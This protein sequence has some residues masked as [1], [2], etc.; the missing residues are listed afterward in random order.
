MTDMRFRA[1]GIENNP[2]LGILKSRLNSL[3]ACRNPEFLCAGNP[4]RLR[5]NTRK[6][7][8]LHMSGIPQELVHQVGTDV[9]GTKNRDFDRL[10]FAH[11]HSS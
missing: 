2:D 7:C 5:V 1:G 10:S 4:F 11:D 8:Q 3:K 6:H 9:A